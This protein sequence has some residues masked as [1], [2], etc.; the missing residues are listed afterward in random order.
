MDDVSC[1]GNETNIT[2]CHHNTEDNCDSGEG[3][4]VICDAR[5]ITVI[6]EERRKVRKCFMKDVD[7]GGIWLNQCV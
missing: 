7:L 2:A 1:T 4:G 3:A 5:D 6:E